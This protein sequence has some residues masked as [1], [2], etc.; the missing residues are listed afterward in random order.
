MRASWPRCRN[1]LLDHLTL[2][3]VCPLVEL[4]Y[5]RFKFR[6]DNTSHAQALRFLTLPPQ[7]QQIKVQY[8]EIEVCQTALLLLQL[9]GSFE[10]RTC[11][12]KSL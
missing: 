4:F 6:P 8:I 3:H 12:Q 2:C 1:C 10:L 5:S 11:L 9:F 7:H